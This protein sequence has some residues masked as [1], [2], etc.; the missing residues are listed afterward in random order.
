ML[1][2]DIEMLCIPYLE[3]LDEVQFHL[4]FKDDL[5]IY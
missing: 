5:E 1:C 3:L 4:L 2:S